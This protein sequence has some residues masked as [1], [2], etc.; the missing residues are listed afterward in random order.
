MDLYQNAL[1]KD[2]PSFPTNRKETAQDNDYSTL[3]DQQEM[4]EQSVEVF[5]N[6]QRICVTIKSG[7][8]QITIEIDNDI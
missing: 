3:P 6:G 2:C 1:R 7:R 5:A 4:A 8:Y